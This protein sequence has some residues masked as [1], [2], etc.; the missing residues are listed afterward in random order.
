MLSKV[1]M[2]LENIEVS[3]K[4]WDGDFV[5]VI[6]LALIDHFFIN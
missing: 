3:H 1:L 5:H 6:G 4:F 2:S